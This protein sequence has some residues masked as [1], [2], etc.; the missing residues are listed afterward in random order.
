VGRA[1]H[2]SQ[3]PNISLGVGLIQSEKLRFE[4]ACGIHLVPDDPWARK[5]LL[6]CCLTEEQKRLLTFVVSDERSE[7]SVGLDKMTYDQVWQALTQRYDSEAQR[8][9]AEV[10]FL[11]MPYLPDKKPSE[12]AKE[13]LAKAV[14]LGMGDSVGLIRSDLNVFSRLPP[15]L[16]AKVNETIALQNKGWPELME[17]LDS[18][19]DNLRMRPLPYRTRAGLS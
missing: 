19:W 4:E 3:A 17:H 9:N 6:T 11:A 8:R 12:F 15:P 13:M 1:F 14:S 18:C 5:Y 7:R 10:K 16:R 2:D